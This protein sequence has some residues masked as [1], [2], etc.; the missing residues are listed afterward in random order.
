MEFQNSRVTKSSYDTEVHEMTSHFE[1]L[2]R[3]YL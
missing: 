2:N 1:L 3:E